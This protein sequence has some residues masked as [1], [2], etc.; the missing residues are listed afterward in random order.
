VLEVPPLR[1]R[2][3]DLAALPATFTDRA[4]DDG[5]E[6][7]W[8][9]GAIQTLSRVDWPGN[10]SSL[11]ALVRRLVADRSTGR[12]IGVDDLP[13]EYLARGARRQLASLEQT[14]A[15]AIMAAL[16]AAGGNKNQAAISLGIARSTLYRKVHALGLDLSSTVY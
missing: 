9:P 16:R 3:D 15:H 12:P 5:V 13:P 14:E 11:D 7:E 4:S 1:D 10:L 8:T 2:I 6:V